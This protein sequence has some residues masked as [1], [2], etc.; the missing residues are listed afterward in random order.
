MCLVAFV[1]FVAA[2]EEGQRS[3]ECIRHLEVTNLCEFVA[4]FL[5]LS[6]VIMLWQCCG[7][8]LISTNLFFE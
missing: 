5:M 6:H 4:C 7:V 2:P 8:F 3:Y 1:A